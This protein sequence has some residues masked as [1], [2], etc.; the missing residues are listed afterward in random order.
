MNAVCLEPVEGR[1]QHL[2]FDLGLHLC[3]DAAGRCVCAHA[4]GI[5]ASVAFAGALV[6][7]ARRQ[8]DEIVARYNGVNGGFFAVQCFFDHDL[9]AASAEGVA[10]EHVF[11]RSNRFSLCFR[12]DHAF[13]SCEAA[14]F[15]D[16][17]CGVCFE[18][19]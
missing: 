11:D 2:C 12:H 17:R 7:L 5:E 14:G 10:F 13:A 1:A 6:V 9:V 4:A 18:I 16:D 3:S 15:D 19:L 8:A